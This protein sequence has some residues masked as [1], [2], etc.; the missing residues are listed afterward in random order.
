MNKVTRFGTGWGAMIGLG[1]WLAVPLLAQAPPT[2]F[3]FRPEITTGVYYQTWESEVGEEITEWTAPLV[4]VLPL[5]SRISVDVLSGPA[6]AEHF[7]TDNRLEGFTD[8]RIRTSVLL[9]QETLLLTAGVNL[10]TGNSD[11][12]A[13]QTDVA[14]A[15]S[16]NA[17][18][19][20][21]P[22]F[23]L[24][25]GFNVGGVIAREI[26][27]WMVIG[28]GASFQYNGDFHPLQDSS[29]V[30]DPG[31]EVDLTFGVDLG[32][33]RFSLTGDVT[34]TLY[35]PDRVNGAE[36]FR[37]GNKLL[38]QL[39]LA[40]QWSRGSS[41]FYLRYR[42][43]G[44]NQRRVGGQALKDERLNSNGDQFELEIAT[45]FFLSRWLG[46]KLLADGKLY[47]LNEYDTNGAVVAGGGGGLILNLSKWLSLDTTAKYSRGGL[48]LRDTGLIEISGLE[49]GAALHW[50]L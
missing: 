16:L 13:H 47:L 6:R 46:V 45:T 12:E 17:L 1:M 30:Y 8:T 18:D 36:V 44:K 33:E 22:T 49:L 21:T 15:L 42:S 39:L 37:S 31:N 41:R 25:L 19:F 9:A 24:G 4:V 2:E 14:A 7:P 35:G 20:R 3:A 28:A 38:I 10:P 26:G 27:D 48:R 23:G 11:L 34:Y 43:K 50:R 32:G 29:L 40:Q 5:N